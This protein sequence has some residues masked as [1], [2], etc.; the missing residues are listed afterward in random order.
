MVRIDFD[1]DELQSFLDTAVDRRDEVDPG[2]VDLLAPTR[3]SDL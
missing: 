2:I 1:A 3:L